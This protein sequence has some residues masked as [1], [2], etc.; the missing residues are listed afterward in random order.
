[1]VMMMLTQVFATRIQGLPDDSVDCTGGLCKRSLGARSQESRPSINLEH[2]LRSRISSIYSDNLSQGQSGEGMFEDNESPADWNSFLE[3]ASVQS[4]A[5]PSRKDSTAG[6]PSMERRSRFNVKTQNP[7]SS[8]TMKFPQE[9]RRSLPQDS[10]L[11]SGGDFSW[12][13]AYKPEEIGQVFGKRQQGWHIQYGKRDSIEVAQE[14][15]VSGSGPIPDLALS[16]ESM[17]QS[18][19]DR[20]ISLKALSKIPFE[21]LDF[22][23][24]SKGLTYSERE[25]L[26]RKLTSLME[27]LVQPDKSGKEAQPSEKVSSERSWKENLTP[28]YHDRKLRLEGDNERITVGSNPNSDL[29]KRQQGWH[30]N[31]GKRDGEAPTIF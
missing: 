16:T 31:Y 17:R 30:I 27:K 8:N 18:Y 19:P 20:A 26:A 29:A 4:G 7:T 22:L 9:K 25:L 2:L 3:D 1:M 24:L 11:Q 23:L 13:A 28:S 5:Q 6:R 12:H 14:D 21:A 10:N 15:T